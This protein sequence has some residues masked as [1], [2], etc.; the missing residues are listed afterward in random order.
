MF[1]EPD[2]GNGSKML[3]TGAQ[4]FLPSAVVPAEGGTGTWGVQ[5]VASPRQAPTAPVLTNPPSS[6]PGVRSHA[7][8]S[9]MGVPV[10]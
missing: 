7:P 5:R 2:S 8:V 1:S 3:P 4:Q 6:Q 10:Q 9:F